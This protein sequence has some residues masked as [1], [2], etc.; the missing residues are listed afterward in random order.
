MSQ[1]PVSDPPAQLAIEESGI[2]WST[3]CREPARSPI[4]VNRV[5]YIEPA[6]QVAT[7]DSSDIALRP[8]H[9][10]SRIVST[11]LGSKTIES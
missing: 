2:T 4:Q 1:D 8:T 9:G 6:D 3:E 7:I 5:A 11:Q 10:V